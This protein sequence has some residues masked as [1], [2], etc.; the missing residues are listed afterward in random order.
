MNWPG[1]APTRRCP[2]AVEEMLRYDTPLQLFERRA[3]SDVEI[4]GRHGRSRDRGRRPARLGQPRS[5][6]FDEP[7]RFDL[8][9]DPNP[10]LA[11]GAGIHFCL[12]AP[13][14][15]LELRVAAAL[16]DASPVAPAGEPG[17]SPDLRPARV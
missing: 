10:H 3:P 13:L 6:R 15:R 4:G 8:G 2:T 16:L 17:A 9:R 12:G 7:D 11:F 14:A 5:G 1:S